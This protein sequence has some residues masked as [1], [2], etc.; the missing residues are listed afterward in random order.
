MSQARLFEF[1]AKLDIN[2]PGSD[3]SVIQIDWQGTSTN[4]I[5]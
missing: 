3:P 1:T 5:D 4:A 2:L